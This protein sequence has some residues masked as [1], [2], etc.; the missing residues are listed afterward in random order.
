MAEPGKVR[1]RKVFIPEEKIRQ[2]QELILNTELKRAYLDIETDASLNPT[3]VGIFTEEYG[4][5]CLV[6]PEISSDKLYR[7]FENIDVVV[8]YNGERFDL[9]VLEKKLSFKLPPKV[10]S[11]D[12][13]YLCWEFDLYGGLK[14]VEK[15]LGIIRDETV[16]GFN[17]LDAVKLWHKYENGD[18]SAL[19]LLKLYNYYDVRNLVDL[20]A[21]LRKKLVKKIEQENSK[22]NFE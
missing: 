19:E 13:M 5:S 16:D 21:R 22:F 14:K 15:E 12:L 2:I 10:H 4:F 7:L 18:R 1:S 11:L 6:Y 3:V 20:E 8:T 9:D 17:G